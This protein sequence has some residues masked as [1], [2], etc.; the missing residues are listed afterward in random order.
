MT[1][2]LSGDPDTPGRRGCSMPDLIS[3]IRRRP[4]ASAVIGGDCD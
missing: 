1:E 2:Y 4:L 3:T